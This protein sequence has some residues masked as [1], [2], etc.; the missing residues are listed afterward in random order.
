MCVQY[1]EREVTRTAIQDLA[2]QWNL[3]F[4]ETSAKKN[5][6]VHDVFE[7]LTRQMR[8]RYP[9]VLPKKRRKPQVPDSVGLI[10]MPR[11]KRRDLSGL[12][13]LGQWAQRDLKR[14]RLEEP[15]GDAG[16]KENVSGDSTSFTAYSPELCAASCN[17]IYMVNRLS[18]TAYGANLR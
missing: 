16:N 9:D 8:K 4:F 1:T 15:S 6:H 18:P 3:P 7:A 17:I 5:W 10:D 11:R 13:N 12:E 14:R 2:K